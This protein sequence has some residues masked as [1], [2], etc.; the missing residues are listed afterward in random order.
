MRTHEP[1]SADETADVVTYD[2]EAR[3]RATYDHA[4]WDL[5]AARIDA[6]RTR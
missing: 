2:T 3:P 1:L 4:R 5:V 6:D